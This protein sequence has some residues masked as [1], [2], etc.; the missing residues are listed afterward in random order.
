[1]TER[2]RRGANAEF[3][4]ERTQFGPGIRNAGRHADGRG[5]IWKSAAIRGWRMCERSQ[6]ARAYCLRPTTYGPRPRSPR[7]RAGWGR[8]DGTIEMSRGALS[9]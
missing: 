9:C 1:L 4:A 3:S 5:Y 2:T 6:F 7:T 8:A